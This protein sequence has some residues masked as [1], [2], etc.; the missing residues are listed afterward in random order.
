MGHERV[1]VLPSTKTWRSIVDDLGAA[2]E[3]AAIPQLAD[4]TLRAVRDRYADVP[5]DR[6]VES[7]F[8]FMVALAN[9]AR[10]EFEREWVGFPLDLVGNPTPVQLTRQLR[11]WVRSHAESLEYADL[12][13]RA[14][15]DVIAD[16]HQRHAAQHSLFGPTS[17]ADV[18]SEATSAA[19]F[20]DISRVFFGK[21]TERYL[22]YFLEREASSVLPSIDARDAFDRV[23]QL[24]VSSVARHTF[25]S[26]KIMQSFAAGWFTKFGQGQRPSR[27]EIRRF[28]R[29]AFEK[30]RAELARERASA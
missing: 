24:H 19:A 6:G 4:K 17:A 9:A 21:L 7:A 30:M 27:R 5:N 26:A 1:G 28:L 29:K 25:E 16:W 12:A 8:E 20:C 23:L 22:R 13:E 10:P 3:V 14:V 18:W 11:T 2:T 15:A